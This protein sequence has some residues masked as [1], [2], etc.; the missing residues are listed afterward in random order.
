MKLTKRQPKKGTWKTSYLGVKY[1]L[2]CTEISPKCPVQTFLC[3]VISIYNI[4]CHFTTEVSQQHLSS[5]KLK[6]ALTQGVP[7][8]SNHYLN[9]PN[10]SKNTT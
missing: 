1:E 4:I 3:L 7:D 6:S 5:S 8:L 10:N 2:L 9:L